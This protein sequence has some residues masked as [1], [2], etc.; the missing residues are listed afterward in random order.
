MVHTDYAVVRNGAYRRSEIH[1]INDHNERRK[2]SY[3][4]ADIVPDRSCYNIHYKSPE[5]SYTEI[6][7]SLLAEK[8]VSTRGLKGDAILFD[9][10]LLDINS[11]YF[12]ERGGYEYAS[13]FY[14]VAYQYACQEVG[15]ENILSAVMHAD[16]RNKALSEALGHDVWHYHLHIVYLPV[17]KKEIKYTKRCKDPALV[18]TVKEVINQI[19]HSKRWASQ[20]LKDEYGNTLYDDAGKA[21]LNM[22]YSQLQTRFALHMQTHG[23]TDIERGIEGSRTKHKS[24]IEYKLKQDEARAKIAT[25]KANQLEAYNTRLAADIVAQK[26]TLTDLQSMEQYVAEVED[27]KSILQQ[28]F[29]MM[30]TFSARTTLFRD[31]KVENEFLDRLKEQL[32]SFFAKLRNLL[33]FEVANSLNPIQC[34]SPRLAEEGHRLA[35][36]LQINDATQR[37]TAPTYQKEERTR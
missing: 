4:N 36:D 37:N 9:E 31:K 16:E 24:V 19:S 17:I 2:E 35:L 13:E 7:D 1:G 27:C 5:K 30:A 25:D 28:I 23:Y 8:K 20:P 11:Q 33:G 6:L 12:E 10:L 32:L 34:E 15:E 14:G 22:S 29:Q 21:M 18:G 26:E 3:R